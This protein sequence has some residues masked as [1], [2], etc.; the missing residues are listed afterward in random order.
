M[1]DVVALDG[2]IDGWRVGDTA[3]VRGF[4]QGSTRDR[5]CIQKDQ[6]IID[7]YVGVCSE[8]RHGRIVELGIAAGGSTALLALLTEPA[9]LVACDIASTPV[10]AL[11]E[12]IEHEQLTD[13]VRPFYGV[14]QGDKGRLT[15]I[16]DR[17]LGRE[18]IDLV[19]DD[20]SHL[21]DKTLASFEVL[22]PRL[23]PGGSFVIED[24]ATQYFI[25]EE[26]MDAVA[27]PSSPRYAQ[28]KAQYDE[29]MHTGSPGRPPLARL[30][31]ELMLAATASPEVIAEVAVNRHW[32]SVRRGPA[33]LDP[34][35]FRLDRYFSDH[36]SWFTD[37][38]ASS[39]TWWF[40]QLWERFAEPPD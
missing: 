26:M 1:R 12:F 18:P 40:R 25:G 13:I 32:I 31:V 9:K 33:A 4:A 10:A 38:P 6:S 28:F 3:F 22:Y 8:F 17:E 29:A 34:T 20:A 21:W 27:N 14:D 15:D 7:L 11:S 24:W 35:D 37:D 2:G 36:F 16:M 30:G 23:R 19:V 39:E 5:F